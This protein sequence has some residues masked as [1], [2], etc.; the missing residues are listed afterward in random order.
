LSFVALVAAATQTAQGG[1]AT[2][3]TLDAINEAGTIYDDALGG[4]TRYVTS[5]DGS[6]AWYEERNPGTT[7]LMRRTDSLVGAPPAVT[8]Y[9]TPTLNS[10]PGGDTTVFHPRV[11]QI[12][13]STL[14][15][16]LMG[17]LPT[18]SYYFLTSTDGGNSFTYQGS[19]DFATVNGSGLMGV[20]EVANAG[21]AEG[22]EV[23]FYYQDGGANIQI[24]GSDPTATGLAKYYDTTGVDSH[25]IPKTISADIS[26]R[27]GFTPSGDVFQLDDGSFALFYVC[28]DDS[29]L[30][31]LESPD[32]LTSW[33]VTRDN[34]NPVIDSQKINALSPRADFR[35]AALWEVPGG[36]GG[37]FDGSASA[38]GKAIGNFTLS[39]PE[40]S[41]LVLSAL[42]L[43]GLL[44]WGRRRRRENY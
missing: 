22:K 43:L 34:T 7:G 26:S 44:A 32:G 16:Y 38:G 20:V 14:G 17:N 37:V 11:H 5:A 19:T 27:S 8:T 1:L 6:A 39:V 33:S 29:Y 2:V 3:L 12:D 30:G 18:G 36:F 28:Q 41:A 35:E 42:G 21:H 40:P 24:T 31:L 9:T 25:S 4:D 10:L 13:G 15:L 23:R